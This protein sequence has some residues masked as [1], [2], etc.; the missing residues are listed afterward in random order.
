MAQ[1]IPQFIT[2]AALLARVEDTLVRN[3]FSPQVAAPIAATIVACERDGTPSHGLLR[4]PG[5]IEAVRTGYADGTVLPETLSTRDSMIVLDAHQGFTH[6]AL[7]QSRDDLKQRAARTG[8]AVLLIRNAHH[9]AALW[10]D[11]EPFA[12]DLLDESE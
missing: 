8:T 10:P 1:F 11:I 3:G 6:L 2:E 5:Y 7:A 4:L 9:F 12:A